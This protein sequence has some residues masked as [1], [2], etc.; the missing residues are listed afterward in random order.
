[1]R[2]AALVKND[3]FQDYQLQKQKVSQTIFSGILILYFFI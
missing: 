1:M 2:A 3:K